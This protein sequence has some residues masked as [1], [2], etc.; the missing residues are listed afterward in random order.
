MKLKK[1]VRF[2]LLLFFLTIAAI[3]PFPIKFH[4]KDNLPAY[5]VE[6]LDKKEDEDNEDDVYQA[7]S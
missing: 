2:L 4:R 3:V 6:Q 1:F 7:F 5:K